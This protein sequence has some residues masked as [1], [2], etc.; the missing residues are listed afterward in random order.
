MNL[1]DRPDLDQALL[2]DWQHGFP[3]CRAPFAEVARQ[4]GSE[5]ATVLA[6]YSRLQQDGC[7]SRIGGVWGAGAG[8]AAMLCAL[9]VPATQLQAVAQRVNAI[10]GVNHNYERE[11][12]YNLWFVITGR[13]RESVHSEVDALELA[14]G[15]RALRLP[16]LR[17]YRIDLGFD[18]R[19]VAPVNHA[20][21]SAPDGKARGSH[22][23]A[24]PVAR[25]DERLAALVEE[26][27]P[28]IARPYEAWAEALGRPIEDILQ[29]LT[30]WLAQGT[31]RR[32]GVVVRHHNLGIT[33]NA[34]TVLD[35]PDT[36]V[37]EAG[38]RLATQ[39]GI[40]LCYRRQ[41]A[42][43]WPYNLYFMVHGQ[44]RAAVNELIAQ[45]LSTSQ[46]G[47]LPRQTLFSGQ[48]FK[49]TGGRYFRGHATPIQ[50]EADHE[51]AA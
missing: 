7:I 33:A 19:P 51:Q 9:A 43:G 47:H 26:G 40:T 2:N 27:L 6:T 17:P 3:L 13:D 25:E 15:L 48:R 20:A 29:T 21:P 11:H 22:T 35:V 5:Q 50:L 34:M 30:R 4:C 1:A 45:A 38:A 36:I 10:P 41:R 39:P 32:L 18:L 46:L 12:R 28:L 23:R 37:D 44:D 24:M 42:Q 49:Q 16:M 31:L 8:G 14:I